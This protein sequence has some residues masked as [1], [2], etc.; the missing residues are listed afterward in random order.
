MSGNSSSRGSKKQDPNLQINLKMSQRLEEEKTTT[1]GN[2]GKETKAGF[3]TSPRRA[4]ST[5]TKR[6][7]GTELFPR[8]RRSSWAPRHGGS[9]KSETGNKKHTPRKHSELAISSGSA[10][11][12]NNPRSNNKKITIRNL[13]PRFLNLRTNKFYGLIG[14]FTRKV[15]RQMGAKTNEISIGIAR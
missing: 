10:E 12:E 3:R 1:R 5:P 2:T 8:G 14:S 11:Q 6:S 13:Q 15:S 9:R 4:P 7:R